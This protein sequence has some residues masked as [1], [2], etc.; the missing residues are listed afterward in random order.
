MVKEASYNDAQ[1]LQQLAE[2]NATAFQVIYER[3][4]QS[5]FSFA[6]YLTKSKDLS[7]EVVQEVFTRVWEKRASLPEQTLLLPYIKKMT[8]NLVLDI[9]RKAGREQAFQQLLYNAM[10][11]ALNEPADALHEKE[12]RRI[13][14]NA[15]ALLPPQKKIIFT[16]S[17]DHHLSYEQIAAKLQLSPNTVRNHMTEAIRS[18]RNHVEKHS[19]VVAA[20]AIIELCSRNPH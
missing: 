10:S 16:L 17:R 8:Q 18:V 7:E 1:L 6:F 11:T 13:Y 15:I 4:Q 19:T 9:F 12:L 14:R 5:V 3:F 2:G 20:A